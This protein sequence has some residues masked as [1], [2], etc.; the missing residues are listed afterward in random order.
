MQFHVSYFYLERETCNENFES[1]LYS[2]FQMK[3]EVVT[4]RGSVHAVCEHNFQSASIYTVVI[5][6]VDVM[7]PHRFP[8]VNTWTPLDN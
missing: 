1:Y 3:S 6:D 4:T 2:K 7:E 8:P 5:R